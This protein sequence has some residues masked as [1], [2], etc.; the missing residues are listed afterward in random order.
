MV[1]EPNT[2]QRLTAMAIV[3][4]L[5]APYRRRECIMAALE[6]TMRLLTCQLADD[7]APPNMNIEH[8]EKRTRSSSGQSKGNLI[9]KSSS[10][11]CVTF[12]QYLMD[13]TGHGGSQECNP[14][15]NQSKHNNYLNTIHQ[16]YVLVE[17][18]HT[19][20]FVEQCSSEFSDIREMRLE[21]IFPNIRCTATQTGWYC[22][23]I[24]VRSEH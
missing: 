22:A 13:W 11:A 20:E 2:I 12:H 19:H 18:R 15:S 14:C 4:P 1:L 23:I 7:V 17:W 21:N 8:T 6:A 3:H 5:S 9:K 24:R 16:Q 10:G